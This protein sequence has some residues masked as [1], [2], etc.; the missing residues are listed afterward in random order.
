MSDPTEAAPTPAHGDAFQSPSVEEFNALLGGKYEVIERVGAGGMGAVYKAKQPIL[1]RIVA[2]K[3]L[4]VAVDSTGELNYRERFH[5]EAKAMAQLDHPNIISVMEF[6]ET[7]EGAPYFVMEYVDGADLHTLIHTT[8]LELAHVVSWFP[9]ICQALEYAHGK[10]MVHCDIKPANIIVS[11]DGRVKVADFGLV[12]LRAD[13]AA[14]ESQLG[15]P[16]YSAPEVFDPQLPVDHRADIFSLGILMYELLTGNPPAGE[17]TPPSKLNAAVD[18]RYD[19]LV[20][21]CVQQD[22]AQRYQSA[23]QLSGALTN[24]ASTP[25][26]PSQQTAKPSAALVAGGAAKKIPAKKAAAKRPPAKKTHAKKAAI[27]KTPKKGKPIRKPVITEAPSGTANFNL[28]FM[29]L[30]IVVGVVG[31]VI[32]AMK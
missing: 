23:T 32:W 13:P 5:R 19:N 30:L 17:W 18:P 25:Y 27:K 14:G 6:G 1:E 16:A 2:I 22:P 3:L 7:P 26:Q 12:Q 21:H 15:T 10:G 31:L 9:L 24:I 28:F 20:L 8:K 4:P 29:I 11:K